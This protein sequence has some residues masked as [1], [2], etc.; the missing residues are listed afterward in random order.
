VI[1]FGR[2][3]GRWPDAG[4]L[5]RYYPNR[6]GGRSTVHDTL[7]YLRDIGLLEIRGASNTRRWAPTAHGFAFLGKP[8]FVPAEERQRTRA[9]ATILADHPAQ[10]HP[11]AHVLTAGR[12]M[13]AYAATLPTFD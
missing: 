13:P 2:R 3:R 6:L 11:S 9:D 5:R 8:P 7:G 1:R 4:A 10:T 12:P